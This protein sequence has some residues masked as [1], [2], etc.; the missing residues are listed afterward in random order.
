MSEAPYKS[1]AYQQ[2]VAGGTTLAYASQQV[3]AT[4]ASGG[5]AL[6]KSLAE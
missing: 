6:I 2:H 3:T 1:C 5:E 4:G